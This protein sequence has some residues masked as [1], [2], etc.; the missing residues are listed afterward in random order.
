[1]RSLLT[2]GLSGLVYI[3]IVIICCF[4]GLYGQLLLS[5]LFIWTAT[6]EWSNFDKDL[7]VSGYQPALILTLITISISSF[8]F[9]RSVTSLLNGFT[10]LFF[11]SWIIH[12]VM[13][14]KSKVPKSILHSSFGLIY[15]GFPLLLLPH[16]QNFKGT[17]EPWILVSLF[18][19]IWS[20]DTFAFS[21][22]K[23]IG[24]TK[25]F[26]RVSPNKT[27]EGFIG[28]FLFTLGISYI[29]SLYFEFLN[30]VQWLGLATLV[31]LMSTLGDL[32][33]SALK[34]SFGLKDS[35]KI[36]PGHG[37]ILD[38]IDSLLFVLPIAYF[39]L[40]ILENL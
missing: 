14:K 11:V 9:D 16:I 35:G 15:I 25:L 18:I 21:V 24:K 5:L 26:E 7:K 3:V 23:L 10:F 20:S 29:L 40:R 8:A 39:Y 32:F 22:G 34:R 27:W 33:E 37:G 38:R 2:R 31:V 36:M 4:T 17:K 30:S 12:L 19:L 6:L 28:G 13:S 1:M